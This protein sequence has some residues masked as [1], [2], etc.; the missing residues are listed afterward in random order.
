[1]TD[2][3]RDLQGLRAAQARLVAQLT[4][5]DGLT[6]EQAR[7]PSLLP[8]WTVGHVLT[9]IARNADAFRGVVATAGRGESSP[10][11]PGG[12]EQRNGDI[13]SGAG[14]SAAALVDDVVS[15]GEALDAA[16]ATTTDETWQTGA[17]AGPTGAIPLR[18]VPGRRW[19]EIAVHHADLGLGYSWS[20]WPSDFVR[21]DLGRMTSHWASKQPMGA[22]TLPVEALQTPDAQRLAWLL[23][24]ADIAGLDPAGAM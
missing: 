22:T 1:V 10:M 15:A 11:Y 14:R 19:R 8:G 16:C 7:Q 6:D 24:R 23:G 12:M 17:G 3:E 18:E 13:E 20:D 5:P 2:L 4:G 21:V 9:H